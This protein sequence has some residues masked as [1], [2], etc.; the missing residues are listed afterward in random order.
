[1][2]TTQTQTLSEETIDNAIRAA[3]IDGAH[4]A[5]VDTQSH[6]PQVENN[7]VD[8]GK[9]PEVFGRLW[10]ECLSV[11]TLAMAPALNV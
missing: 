11:F 6:R 7:D 8:D 10:R 2:S 3:A 5:I 4:A 9:T 1:M